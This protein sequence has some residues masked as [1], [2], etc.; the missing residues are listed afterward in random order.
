[1]PQNRKPNNK[2][3]KATNTTSKARGLKYGYRSGLEEKT[4]KQIEEAGLEVDYENHKISYT[5]PARNSTYTPDFRLPKRE[6]VSFMWR[7][8]EG[9]SQRIDTSI[10]LSVINTLT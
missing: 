5:I 10:C 4:S 2:R 7:P 1:M 9:G 6:A 3:K 8:K